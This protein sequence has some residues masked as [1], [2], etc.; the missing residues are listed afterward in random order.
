[1]DIELGSASPVRDWGHLGSL[2]EAADG[3]SQVEPDG[4]VLGPGQRYRAQTASSPPDLSAGFVP[5]S[6]TIWCRLYR[7]ERAWKP[8]RSRLVRHP[9]AE[10]PEV[11]ALGVGKGFLEIEPS[12]MDCQEVPAQ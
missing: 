4:L 2:I 11:Y 5:P 1:V 10:G 12:G 7:T 9:G 3:T 6:A 8:P